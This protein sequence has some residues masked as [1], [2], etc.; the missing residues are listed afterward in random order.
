M[1]AVEYLA[2]IAAVGLVLVAHHAGIPNACAPS[3]GRVGQQRAHTRHG[4]PR[5]GRSLRP[6]CDR[7]RRSS[8]ER[9]QHARRGA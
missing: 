4:A 1:Q 3:A 9:I 6:R 2:V 7:Q 8:D 5:F